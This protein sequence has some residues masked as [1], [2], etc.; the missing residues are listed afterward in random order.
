MRAVEVQPRRGDALRIG[1][2][3]HEAAVHLRRSFFDRFR[4]IVQVQRDLD[5]L[6]RFALL[7]Q[8]APGDHVLG[9]QR[10]RRGTDAGNRP[11][12]QDCGQGNPRQQR[13]QVES[14]EEAQG[15]FNN[16]A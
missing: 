11:H 10:H 13:A 4:G 5:V 2:Q 7:V 8:H 3:Q 9:S 16:H 6:H 1:H 12:Q 14:F 15:G